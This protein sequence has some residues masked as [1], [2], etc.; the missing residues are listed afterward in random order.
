MLSLELKDFAKLPIFL[1]VTGKVKSI[2]SLFWGMKRWP[3]LKLREVISKNHD[4]AKWGLYRAKATRF[5]G[6]IREMARLL[7]AKNDLMEVV[8]SSEYNQK[9]ASFSRKG[10]VAGTDA[11]DDTEHLDQ[12]IGDA[13]EMQ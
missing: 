6:K 8:M 2:L 5:A 10:R 9:K 3:R 13:K 1:E 12:N 7:R 4:G 11:D